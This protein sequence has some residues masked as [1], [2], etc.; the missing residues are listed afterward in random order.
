MALDYEQKHKI[1]TQCFRTGTYALAKQNWDY[2]I[3]MFGRAITQVPDNLLYRQSYRGALCRKFDDNKTGARMAGAKLMGTRTRI[4]KARLQSKW[5]Q[6][7]QEAT[8][9]LMVNPWDSWLNAEIGEAC[10][11]LGYSEVAQFFYEK[12]LEGDPDNK[13]Y[14]RQLARLL[15]QRGPLED[16]AARGQDHDGRRLRHGQEHAAGPRARPERL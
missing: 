2:A 7:D 12:A 16:D 1:A 13:E 10:T 8:K 4:K 3:D 11:N 14:N 6:V 5:D 15:E 9:G